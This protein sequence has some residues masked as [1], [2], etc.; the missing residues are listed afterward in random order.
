MTPHTHARPT[1]VV[2]WTPYCPFIHVAWCSTSFTKT[3]VTQTP[4][5]QLI[6]HLLLPS[7]IGPLTWL[8]SR[9]PVKGTNGARG[10]PHSSGLLETWLLVS[11][12]WDQGWSKKSPKLW[13]TSPPGSPQGHPTEDHKNL[14]LTNP[15]FSL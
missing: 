9:W 4:D 2:T 11:P 5:P 3:V 15:T 8:I 12:G 10:Q 1:L 13:E 14:E 7:D 6:L